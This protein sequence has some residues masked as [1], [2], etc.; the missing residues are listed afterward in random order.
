MK[1]RIEIN[2]DNV[3]VKVTLKPIYK[4]YRKT[5]EP[6]EGNYITHNPK[7]ETKAISN[8]HY[9]VFEKIKDSGCEYY[10]RNSN[11]KILYEIIKYYNFDIII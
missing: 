7:S 10:Y 8:V 4:C 9:Q 2:P 5:F 3:W 6:F 1:R 11:Q